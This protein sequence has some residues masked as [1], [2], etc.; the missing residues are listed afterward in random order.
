LAVL[1]GGPG[2][3]IVPDLICSTALDAVLLAGHIPVFADVTSDRW[4]L[5]SADARQKITPNT[6]AVLVAHLFGHLANVPRG[7]FADLG[8]PIVEDA[9]QGLGGAVGTI[10]DLTVIGFASSKMIGGRGGV[11]LTDY[12]A[13]SDA[14]NAISI[15]EPVIEIPMASEQLRGYT[16]QLLAAAPDLIR[17]FDD[18]LENIALI[19]TGWTKLAANVRSRNEKAAYLHAQLR[20]TPL[21]LPEIML[22][23]AIWRYTI[24]A[25]AAAAANRIARRLQLAGLPGSR[26]YPS[27]SAIFAPDSSLRSA[28]IAPRLVNLWVDSSADQAALARMVE[29]IN[30]SARR[31]RR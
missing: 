25:P 26:L 19:E 21:L 20:D 23:D 31:V 17:P 22:G 10:G 16:P 4:T 24:T 18:S 27:L 11:V 15:T 5:D 29:V 28:T 14:I 7:A 8:V 30:F 3:I 9:V 2:E 1:N 6:Q 12:P 13:L